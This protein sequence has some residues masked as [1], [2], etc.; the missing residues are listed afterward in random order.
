MNDR[1]SKAKDD[2]DLNGGKIPRY[3]ENNF[4]QSRRTEEDKQIQSCRN[5]FIEIEIGAKDG[6]RLLKEAVEVELS[7]S[8]RKTMDV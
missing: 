4:S 5:E 1:I 8:R 2:L 3:W 6:L 7:K